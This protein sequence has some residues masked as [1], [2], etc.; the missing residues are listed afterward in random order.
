ML[1]NWDQMMLYMLVLGVSN[2]FYQMYK[3]KAIDATIIIMILG[4]G[5]F[6]TKLTWN[7]PI[8]QSSTEYLISK[9]GPGGVGS[10]IGIGIGEL[11]ANRRKNAI[12]ESMGSSQLNGIMQNVAKSKK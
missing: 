5:V 10:T 6:F 7:I 11:L 3:I 2:Y 9:M 12:L 8:V 1:Q 4:V